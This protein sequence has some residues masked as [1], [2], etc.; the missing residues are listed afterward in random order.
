E[1][2]KELTALKWPDAVIGGVGTAAFSPDGKRVLTAGR[3]GTWGGVSA[4][5]PELPRVWDAS[6]GKVLFHLKAEVRED[7]QREPG[8][9]AAFSP[10]GKL[11][12]TAPGDRTARVWDA[13]TG[14]GL[15]AL[16]GHEGTV[17]AP[18]FSP[19][20]RRV[21]TASEDGTARVWRAPPDAESGPETGHWP[22]VVLATFSPDGKRL[23]TVSEPRHNVA[24]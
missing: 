13:A 17:G 5:V 20:G 14:T 19:D 3:G 6:N 18:A 9:D 21:A 24:R 10:D 4:G 15:P 8:H 23:V 16:R 12:V 7:G 11:V 22:E 2:G 1:T